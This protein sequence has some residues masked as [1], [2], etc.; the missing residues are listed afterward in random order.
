M[1]YPS[2]SLDTEDDVIAPVCSTDKYAS[3]SDDYHSE[4]LSMS[5][6]IAD[7][8]AP[9]FL[10]M[11]TLQTQGRARKICRSSQLAVSWVMG[12]TTVSPFRG[13][14]GFESPSLRQGVCLTGA[15]HGYRR[16]RPGFAGSVSLDETRERD[17]LA[18]RQ[19]TLAAFF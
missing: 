17:A 5:A 2:S 15:F 19:L 7:K 9:I 3:C 14:R 1:L 10:N 18:T 16:K 11:K 4:Q 8:L 6:G 13:D 12:S